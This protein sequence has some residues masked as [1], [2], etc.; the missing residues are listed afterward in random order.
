MLRP[1]AEEVPATTIRPRPEPSPNACE[2]AL[3]FLNLALEATRT[4]RPDEPTAARVARVIDGL[5]PTSARLAE[6]R[7][8]LAECAQQLENLMSAPRPP[9]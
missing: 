3:L 9:S 7:D 5:A 1:P 8:H 2:R 6:W 4:G